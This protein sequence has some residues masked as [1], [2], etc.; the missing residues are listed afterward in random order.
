MDCGREAPLHAGCQR[1]RRPLYKIVY[2]TV[3]GCVAW[4]RN[5]LGL[6]SRD[7][8]LDSQSQRGCITSTYMPLSPSSIVS[9]W[10]KIGCFA[11]CHPRHS[12][13]R[14]IAGLGSLKRLLKSCVQRY[15]F[16]VAADARLCS[17][18]LTKTRTKKR[19]EKPP[20][21]ATYSTC[22][23]M[24]LTHI[25]SDSYASENR[26]IRTKSIWQRWTTEKVIVC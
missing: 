25:M 26:N 24:A 12:S 19:R 7:R 22:E 13:C 20:R 3:R 4:W 17:M 15:R 18:L 9:Y 14:L 10:C 23:Q 11:A 1:Q 8:G 6:L 2:W 5:E 16:H 21:F